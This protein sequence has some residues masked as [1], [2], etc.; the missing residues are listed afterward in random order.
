M[1]IVITLQN[2]NEGIAIKP[3]SCYTLLGKITIKSTLYSTIFP[4][5]LTTIPHVFHC[6]TNTFLQSLSLGLK[7]SSTSNSNVILYLVF[8]PQQ[9]ETVMG[10]EGFGCYFVL[11]NHCGKM[12]RITVL[13]CI[14]LDIYKIVISLQNINEGLT[15]K[16]SSC[17]TLLGKITIKTNINSTLFPHYLTTI[18]HVFHSIVYTFP[19]TC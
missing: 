12:S 15:I 5:L 6:L 3:S 16:P 7:S 14:N 10:L 19:H 9:L 4:Q 8:C 1:I 2:I 18:P 13:L 17:Y 11:Y